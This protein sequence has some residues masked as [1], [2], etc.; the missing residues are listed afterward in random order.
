MVALARC[1][2]SLAAVAGGAAGA[3]LAKRGEK[4]ES[5]KFIAGVPVLNYHA[6]YNG[7]N[8]AEFGAEEEWVVMVKP[9]VTDAQIEDMCKKAKN[10][11]NLVGHPSQGGVPFFEMRGTET[12][13][14]EVLRSAPGDVEFVEVDQTLHAIP[15]LSADASVQSLWGLSRVG[16]NERTSTG[17]GVSVFILDTGIR[18]SHSD[19]GGRAISGVD[20]TGSS[21]GTGDVQGHGTH[22]AGTAAGTQYGVASGAT[23]RSVKVLSDQGSGQMSWITGGLDWTARNS[24]SPKVASMSLGGPG[25]SSSMQT[26]VDA[27]TRSGVSVV[28]AGGNSNSDSCNFSPAFVPSAIT[29]GSTDS[30]DRRSSFSNYGR[31][32]NIWA[33]GS[34]IL[35]AGHRSNSGTATLSGTSM[36]CPHVAGGAALIL[37]RN[38]SHNYQKVLQ[39]LHANAINNRISGLTSSDTNK[40]LWVGGGGGSPSPSPS[41]SPPPGCSDLNQNC[42]YWAG[43]GYC[44]PS[45]IYYQ[46]MMQNCCASCS[47]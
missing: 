37:Q 31:C 12:D 7:Q 24:A 16:T 19:F 45:S 26:A 23:I 15:E 18:H 3:R 30:N 4:Q 27:A 47:R 8:L 32:T 2:G 6:A 21:S 20:Y 46:Y 11:C 35:S 36:A 39:D 25:T 14:E 17:T 38:P 22:C 33:P 41:P 29:V 5:P 42:G 1:L 40:F 9:A 10:G 28:V 44:S 13:L 34:S 43:L